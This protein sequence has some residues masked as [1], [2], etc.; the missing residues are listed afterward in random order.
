MQLIDDLSDFEAPEYS[1]VTSGTFDGV[2]VGHQKI[3]ANITQ[4][5]REKNR[6]S[7]VLTFWPHPRFVLKKNNDFKLLT[8]FEEK[9]A[10]LAKNGIDFLVKIPFTKE[11]SQLSSDQFIRDIL[12]KK[13]NT[14]KLVIGYDHRF[15]KNREGSFEYLMEHSD[16]YGFAVEEIP[17]QDVEHIGVSSTKI[18]ESLAI[19]DIRTATE[20]LGR[21]YCISG[22]VKDGD[23]IGRSIGFPTANIDVPETYKLIP[24]DGAYAV[25]LEVNGQNLKGMMNIGQR[26]TVSGE[27]RRIEVNIFDFDRDI[28]NQRITV[29]FVQLLRHEQKFESIDELKNQLGRDKMEAIEILK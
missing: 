28:Y 18:R 29:Q 16:E 9:A 25:K 13:L 17:R 23:R 11:F 1:V 10:L 2:H 22:F 7:I 4:A 12:V 15:G 20:C 14:Q 5:S 6:K 26:P 3:L 24:S 27:E 21:N 8:T 19:G